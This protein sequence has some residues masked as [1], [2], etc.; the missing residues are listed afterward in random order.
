M[1]L[2]TSIPASRKFLNSPPF[3]LSCGRRIPT[4]NRRKQAPALEGID[5]AVVHGWID[6]GLMGKNGFWMKCDVNKEVSGIVGGEMPS[7]KNTVDGLTRVP[8]RWRKDTDVACA[9]L[10]GTSAIMDGLQ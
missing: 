9:L 6:D 2:R 4:T 7:S 8:L 5:S 1:A 10:T 3:A